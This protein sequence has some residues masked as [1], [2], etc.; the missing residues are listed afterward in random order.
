MSSQNSSSGVGGCKKNNCSTNNSVHQQ[1]DIVKTGHFKAKRSQSYKERFCVLRRESLIGPARF[2]YYKYEQRF[3][4]N[5]PPKLSIILSHCFNVSPKYSS[6]SKT[7]Q[8]LLCFYTREDYITIAFNDDK[9][10]NEWLQAILD[11][12]KYDSLINQA[13]YERVWQVVISRKRNMDREKLAGVYRICLTHDKNLNLVKVDPSLDKPVIHELPLSCVRRL[14][15]S[16][17]Y[18]QLELGRGATIG[19]GDLCMTTDDDATARDM[20]EAI[21]RKI[22]RPSSGTPPPT[23]NANEDNVSRSSGGDDSDVPMNEEEDVDSYLPMMPLDQ[24]QSEVIKIGSGHSSS[25]TRSIEEFKPDSVKSYLSSQD[26]EEYSFFD[27]IKPVRAYSM[28][29]RPPPRD[30]HLNPSGPCSSSSSSSIKSH[31]PRTNTLGTNPSERSH[32]NT[33][34]SDHQSR[35]RSLSMGSQNARVQASSLCK[36]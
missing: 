32:P 20:H 18:F 22:D 4:N 12:V 23:F 6:S 27:Y 1:D 26:E 5:L 9:Q 10:L 31:R 21:L 25:R 28:G 24:V 8:H 29:S 36:K 34:K 11:L 17:K 35:V 30:A 2:E 16:R 33:A 7:D 14:G 3:K 15:H 13:K 19:A